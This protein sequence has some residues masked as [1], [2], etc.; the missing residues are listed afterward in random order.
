MSIYLFFFA[1]IALGFLALSIPYMG[2]K[3]LTGPATVVSRRAEAGQIGSRYSSTWLY[4]VTFRLSDG[5]EIELYT[6]ENEYRCLKEG[7]SGILTWNG[8]N[9]SSFDPT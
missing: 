8:E 5:E 1:I 9:F 6:F 2:G 4:L 3:T 7:T